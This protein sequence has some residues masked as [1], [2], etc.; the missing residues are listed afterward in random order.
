MKVSVITMHA[1]KNYGSVLQTYATQTV[2]NSL[3][4]ETEIINYIRKKNLDSNLADTWTANDHGIKKVIKKAIL[5]PTITRWKKVFGGY[6]REN[7]NLSEHTYSS[8]EDFI[9]NPVV[10]DVYCTGSDQVWNSGWNQGIEG[11]FF[12][13]FAPE[14]A[15]K[16]SIAASIGKTELAENEIAAIMPMLKR[17]NA[18]SMREMS[19]VDIVKGMGISNV[20]FC[21]DPTLLL[22]KE[23]WLNHAMG[24]KVPE[25]Y[26]LVYQLN[27]DGKFDDYA[28]EVAKRKKLPLLRVCTRYDQ[29]RLP[30]KAIIIPE[31][32]QLLT[33]ISK[34]ELVITNSFHATAFCINLNKNFI[35][36]YPNEYSCRLGD[37]L[38]MFG[39]QRRHL[40]DYEQYELADEVIDFNPV[41]EILEQKRK[42]SMAVIKYMLGLDK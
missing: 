16:I 31:I 4:C 25:K 35:S 17:Y 37:A 26:I 23:K 28:V 14:T 19:G 30:G 9:H 13:N 1:V 29:Q 5:Y 6:L 15:T 3:G 7:I 12:L 11:P 40:E 21:L 33:L 10:S 32:Q 2:L 24:I 8:T 38:A 39:L 36:I 20:K 42:E 27:H 22:S 34:A 41:N 18:I